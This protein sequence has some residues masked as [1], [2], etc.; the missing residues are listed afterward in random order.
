MHEGFY[1]FPHEQR[2]SVLL[3]AAGG[4]K[5]NKQLPVRSAD[6]PA[7]KSGKKIIFKTGVAY[8]AIWGISEMGVG[9]RLTFFMPVDIN[10]AS[11]EELA[12]IPG[13]G[14]KTAEAIVNYRRIHNR[15]KALH[16]L[17]SLPGLGEKK[18]Q[19]LLPYV[20]IEQ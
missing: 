19:A 9:A 13:I 2:V 16:E 7:I 3:Q 14:T 4:L 11:A 15:V 8:D 1:S 17:G 18:L 6:F 10:S 20:S 12:L 5:E